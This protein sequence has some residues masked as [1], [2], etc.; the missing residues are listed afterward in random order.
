MDNISYLEQKQ[1]DTLAP[2]LNNAAL[3]YIYDENKQMI[4]NIK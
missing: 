3:N 4:I 2:I 1:V